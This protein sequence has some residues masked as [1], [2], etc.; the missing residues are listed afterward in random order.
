MAQESTALSLNS[1]QVATAMLDW[2]H[3]DVML[4]WQ[5]IGKSKNYTFGA[6]RAGGRLAAGGR[7][8]MWQI[9]KPSSC[10]RFADGSGALSTHF[11]FFSI[12]FGYR[13]FRKKRPSPKP[14]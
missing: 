4:D 5:L 3:S 13:V 11:L 7:P 14:I 1:R 2:Q 9:F 12:F 10:C 6:G 8:G